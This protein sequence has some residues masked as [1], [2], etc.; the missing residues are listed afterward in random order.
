[1]R[2]SNALSLPLFSEGLRLSSRAW[3][4]CTEDVHTQQTYNVAITSLQRRCNVV[5]LQRR[6]NDVP[7]TLCVC[8]V[9]GTNILIQTQNMSRNSRAKIVCTRRK[10]AH[11]EPWTLRSACEFVQSCHTIFYFHMK[12]LRTMR[13]IL[14]EDLDQT[15][16]LWS[17][18]WVFFDRT[19]HFFGFAVTRLK[20]LIH[21]LFHFRSNWCRE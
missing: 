9:Y 16:W 5:T 12:C 19:C 13:N 3:N 8:W 18:S 6:F 20:S 14:S 15:G 4:I 1:M 2:T 7:A 21:P 17:L 11:V 10:I